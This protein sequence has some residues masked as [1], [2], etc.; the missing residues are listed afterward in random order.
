MSRKAANLISAQ[1]ILKPECVLG[2]ATGGTPVGVY[3]QLVD[4]YKKGDLDF[5]KVHTV[6]LDEYI[7]L[8]VT[9]PQSYR[10]FMNENLF[11]HVNIPVENTNVPNGNA[12]N[13]EAECLRYETLIDSL[14]GVDMQLLGIGNTGHIGFNE[15]HDRF[16][17]ITHVVTLNEVTIQANAR[18][19]ENDEAKVPR[20]AVT[21]GIRTIMKAQK[22]VLVANGANK[23]EILEKALFGPINPQIPA[24][25]LQ[26]HRDVTVFAD[27]AA[28]AV[29]RDK[30]VQAID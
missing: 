24:S 16:D 8:P 20:R 4:W 25:V 11:R 5:S 17:T 23:A 3:S 19:F 10:S 26:L 14:G 18:F 7:G 22:I 28:L 1:V 9:H 15:P 21:M 2:L 30:H 13:M 6:N 27:E 29:I 12:R